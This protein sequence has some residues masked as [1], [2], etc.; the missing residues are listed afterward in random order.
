M[1]PIM[2][3]LKLPTLG[4]ISGASRGIGRAIAI[5]LAKK[6]DPASTFY[7]TARSMESLEETAHVIKRDVDKKLD[8]RC[9]SIDMSDERS[10]SGFNKSIFS[11]V[12]DISRFSHAV[13]VH[14]A[15]S[16]GIID[17]KARE[18]HDISAIQN[19]FFFN[20]TAPITLT[21]AFLQHLANNHS[22]LRKTVVQITSLSVTA[23]QKSMHLYCTGKAG[24]EIFF[25]VMAL[26]EPDVKILSY[27]PGLVNTDL[28]TGLQSSTDTEM[29]ML[30]KNL[31]GQPFFLSP[32][33]SAETL[34]N[35][36]EE[37]KYESGSIVR[38][39]EVMNIDVGA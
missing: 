24:R 33:Q 19:Y 36:L 17:K 2:S 27:D 35:V 39:Y 9:V 4:I 7:L 15:G 26:E 1:T 34:C 14:N 6:V 11:N 38:A 13:L 8:I 10:V 37:D 16:I 12:G 23:P 21:S 32:Q 28:Y 5:E 22:K 25:R 18:L 20:M 29:R 30:A 31:S 3:M